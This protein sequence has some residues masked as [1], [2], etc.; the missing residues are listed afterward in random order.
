[1]TEKEKKEE[2]KKHKHNYQ[3]IRQEIWE[4]GLGE[5]SIDKYALFMC[6]CGEKIRKVI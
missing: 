4:N 1:M 2:E 5:I 6:E 3:F